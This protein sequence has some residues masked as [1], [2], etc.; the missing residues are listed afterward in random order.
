[1]SLLLSQLRQFRNYRGLITISSC[2]TCFVKFLRTLHPKPPLSCTDI[3][4]SNPPSAPSRPSP[5]PN[6]ETASSPDSL[7][8][9]I[10]S[11]TRARRAS[12][13]STSVSRALRSP[14]YHSGGM[15]SAMAQRCLRGQVLDAAEPGFEARPAGDAAVDGVLRKHAAQA[16]HR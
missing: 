1:M 14:P 16:R 13:R 12:N 6:A 4:A 9:T 2:G 3:P 11:R 5:L 7:N 10:N 8:A 15:I